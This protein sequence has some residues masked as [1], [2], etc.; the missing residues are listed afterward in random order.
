MGCSEQIQEFSQ[1]AGTS[2]SS[3]YSLRGHCGGKKTFIFCG[4]HWEFMI[5]EP[6]GCV[7][8]CVCVDGGGCFQASLNLI[9]GTKRRKM[10]KEKV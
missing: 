10:E 6:E 4:H 2:L 1:Q 3:V 8:V 5:Q 7:C 9:K